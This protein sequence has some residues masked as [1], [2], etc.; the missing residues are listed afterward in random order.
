MMAKGHITPRDVASLLPGS[1][2]TGN[3][4]ICK[5]PSH[6][7]KHAS[8]KVSPGHKATVLFCHAGC[9]VDQVL[10][11]LGLRK[12]QLYYDYEP[13]GQHND[14][15]PD[16][17]RLLQKLAEKHRPPKIDITDGH[18]R[19]DD[20]LWD[21][22]AQADIDK[23]LDSKLTEEEWAEN[24][25]R[26]GVEHRWV[27]ELDYAEAMAYN[28]RDGALFDYLRPLWEKLGRPNWHSLAGVAFDKM[29]R[30]YVRQKKKARVV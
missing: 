28:P 9:T 24:A 29:H 4:Y 20:I 6:E 14:D 13:N 3:G 21:A 19:F 26:V 15:T 22:L 30:E 27:M 12:E 18:I 7:D 5:C 23:G 1:K 17:R 11:E 10:A 8:L 2:R 16:I 25:A